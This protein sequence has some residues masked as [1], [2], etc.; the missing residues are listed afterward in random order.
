MKIAQRKWTPAE[1]WQPALESS[2]LRDC[3][4]LVLVFGAAALLKEGKLVAEVQSA[5]PAAMCLGCSAAGEICGSAMYEQS[6]SIAAIH[7]EKSAVRYA[8][9]DYHGWEDSFSAGERL[10]R[11]FEPAGLSHVLVLSCGLQLNGSEL[12][13]GLEHG[14]PSEVKITGGVAGNYALL[15][16]KFLLFDGKP[17]LTSVA[18]IG[19]YGSTL[20]IGYG[21][22][23]G[24]DPFGPERVITRSKGNVL[25]ELD[26]HSALELYKKYL[27]EYA[28][29]LPD[30]GLF[31]PLSVRRPGD[32]LSFV[33]T[34]HSV[35][36]AEQSLLFLGNVPDGA[37]AR[38]MK[39]NCDRLIDGSGRAARDSRAM[40]GGVQAELAVLVSCAGRKLILK[41]RVDEELEIVKEVLGEDAVQTGFYSAGEIAPFNA[42]SRCF[43]HNQTMTITVFS[44]R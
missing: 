27:G 35:N 5:F 25:Y 18:A 28:A 2:A 32:G 34:I 14:V 12:V 16:D 3:A 22:V 9:V 17:K 36:E 41:Q 44:E 7:L 39:G 1:G 30:T 6:L 19:F 4:Q 37:Y 11:S 13:R 33:R 42:G 38:L 43:F 26:G 40:L 8:C 15:V 21:S 20:K 23:S 29:G 24:F 10:G 31:F